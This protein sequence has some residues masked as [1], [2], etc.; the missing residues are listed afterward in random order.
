[1]LESL[2][3]GTLSD[4]DNPPSAECFTKT[5]KRI[6]AQYPK[7]TL[8]ENE[9]KVSP[10]TPTARSKMPVPSKIS[11]GQIS[12]V[13]ER[14]SSVFYLEDTAALYT[15]LSSKDSNF[16]WD[17]IPANSLSQDSLEMYLKRKFG[18]YKLLTEMSY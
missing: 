10:G 16:T 12:H 3:D 7:P 11:A 2:L 18:N 1:M 15:D 9:T 8:G 17:S 6:L 14:T 4:A 5:C 13:A